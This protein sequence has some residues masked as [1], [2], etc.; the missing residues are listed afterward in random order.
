MSE[1]F[2]ATFSNGSGNRKVNLHSSF[3]I[4]NFSFLIIIRAGLQPIDLRNDFNSSLILSNSYSDY[5]QS[6]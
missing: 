6:A 4:F 3:L 5:L 2:A 1:W